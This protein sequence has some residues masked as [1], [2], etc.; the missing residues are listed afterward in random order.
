M[1][2]IQ[3]DVQTFLEGSK[4][5]VLPLY[6][7]RYSWRVKHWQSLARDLRRLMD[8]PERQSHFIGSFVETP[9][10]HAASQ[11][12]N[13]FWLIDG[14]QR[15]TTIL[16]LLAALRDVAER[17]GLPE[18]ADEVQGLYLSNQYKRGEAA[19]KL[20]PTQE[21]RDDFDATMKRPAGVVESGGGRIGEA[22][23]FFADVLGRLPAGR[24]EEARRAALKRLA[25]VNITLEGGDDP[26]L[27]FESLNAK[28]ERLTQ[29][30]ADDVTPFF[31]HYLTRGADGAG[32]SVA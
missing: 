19:R 4:Q 2:A 26:H 30:E 29:D 3:S 23:R 7:R 11:S 1:K 18:L 28:G 32:W 8:E 31:R 15:L 10:D 17:G 22:Y 16:L 12:V 21:D 6:Q 20:I 13:R 5:F 27:I 24:L 25:V 9:L 14:Q